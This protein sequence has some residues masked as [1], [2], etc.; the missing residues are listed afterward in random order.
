MSFVSIPRYLTPTKISAVPTLAGGGTSFD[1]NGVGEWVAVIFS[2]PETATISGYYFRVHS[3]TQG[4]NATVTLENVTDG[5]PS[6]VTNAFATSAITINTSGSTA[7]YSGSF[8]S[9]FTVNQGTILAFKIAYASNLGGSPPSSISIGVLSDDN[10]GS[11][12]PYCLEFDASVGSPNDG[13]AP[14]FCLLKSDNTAVPIKHCWPINVATTETFS[15]ASNPTHI[16]N[17]LEI[18]APC[19]ISGASI[20]LDADTGGTLKLYGGAGGNTL[21]ASTSI[22]INL[23]N[24]SAMFLVDYYFSA[25]VDLSPGTYYLLVEAVAGTLGIATMTFANA[26]YRSGSPLGGASLTYATRTS[27]GV[28]ATTSTKQAFIAPILSG[29]D[30]G[31]GGGGGETSHVFI[32]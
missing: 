17:A 12:L 29:F 21:L 1:I 26:N 31:G 16:G 27:G 6:G 24:S 18:Y 20:W 23:P 15:S 2:M 19:Q 5:V 30:T 3:A 11:G 8:T 28:F 25:P 22:S 32:G 10:A 9:P 4:C 13:L 14:N 7:D